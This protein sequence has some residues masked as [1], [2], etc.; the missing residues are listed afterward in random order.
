MNYGESCRT[1]KPKDDVQDEGEEIGLGKERN[2]R[3]QKCDSLYGLGASGLQSMWPQLWTWTGSWMEPRE[4]FGQ[5]KEDNLQ[6][7]ARPL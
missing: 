4:K 5:G 6:R 7:W 1:R 2:G 3:A